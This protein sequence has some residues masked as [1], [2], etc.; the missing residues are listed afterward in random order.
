MAD[1]DEENDTKESENMQ[2]EG[3]EESL[4]RSFVAE[5]PDEDPRFETAGTDTS[6]HGSENTSDGSDEQPCESDE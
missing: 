1:D 3:E 6:D 2:E 5:T 4:S